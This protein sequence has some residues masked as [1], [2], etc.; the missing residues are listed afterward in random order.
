MQQLML[1]MSQRQIVH[2]FLS[3][4]NFRP[5]ITLHSKPRVRTKAQCATAGGWPEEVLAGSPWRSPG[6]FGPPSFKLQLSVRDI[7]PRSRSSAGAW[8]SI[9]TRLKS[10][11]SRTPLPPHATFS[12]AGQIPAAQL[13]YDTSGGTTGRSL[14]NGFFAPSPNGHWFPLG[15][16]TFQ[17]NIRDGISRYFHSFPSFP[18]TPPSSAFG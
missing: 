10:K 14:I 17:I 11:G 4:L 9:A 16:R 7:V 3:S 6:V 13:V 15:S 5:V 8:V 18:V 2:G 1:A 12:C